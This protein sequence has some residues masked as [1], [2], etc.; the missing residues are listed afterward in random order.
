MSRRSERN[1]PI[2]EELI[3]NAAWSCFDYTH[4][5]QHSPLPL[6][7]N[8]WVVVPLLGLREQQRA[9]DSLNLVKKEKQAAERAR[10]LLK[11]DLFLPGGDDHLASTGVKNQCRERAGKTVVESDD[12]L[13]QICF[14]TKIKSFKFMQIVLTLKINL[15]KKSKQA[16]RHN[17]NEYLMKSTAETSTST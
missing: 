3:W 2:K 17:R 16:Y 13:L 1:N 5:P 10:T 9:R 7:R 8:E 6:Q 15:N 4:V 14:K 11:L 12:R